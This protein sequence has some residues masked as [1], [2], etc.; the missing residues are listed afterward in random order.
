MLL[1]RLPAI[2]LE[3]ENPL[4][5]FG[6][7]ASRPTDTGLVPADEDQDPPEGLTDEQLAEEDALASAGDLEFSPEETEQ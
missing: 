6:E 4:A 5:H 2:T 7:E 1:D 3:E